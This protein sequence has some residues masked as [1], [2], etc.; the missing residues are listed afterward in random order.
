MVILGALDRSR[1][2][3]DGHQF[4][5]KGGVAMEIRL[6]LRARATRDVDMTFHGDPAQLAAA[7]DQALATPYSGFAFDRGDLVPIGPTGAKRTTIK[8]AYD[9]KGWMTIDLEL[10]TSVAMPTDVE[11]I[12]AISMQDFRL[13]GP[14]HVA[15][16]SVRY[17]IAQ[18]LHAVTETFPDGENRRVRD[19]LD[20]VLLKELAP[21]A[22]HIREACIDVFTERAMH[23]WPPQLLAYDSWPADYAQLTEP[24]AVPAPG[25]EDALESVRK[26]IATI[27]A[28]M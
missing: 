18:K 2:A 28:A 25:F 7:L 11:L 14:A 1:L 19:I 23:E 24:L 8:L 13:D 9:G 10:S 4:V 27:D 21:S 12:P 3:D 15:T 20:L 6:G 5:I 22:S 16:L 26:Y 17:Q